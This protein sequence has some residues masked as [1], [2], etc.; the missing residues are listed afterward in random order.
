MFCNIASNYICG[1]LVMQ[2]Q[3]SYDYSLQKH[4]WAALSS[5]RL[6]YHASIV[7]MLSSNICKKGYF[8]AIMK[9]FFNHFALNHT[10]FPK[11][12]PKK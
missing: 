10:A 9:N 8:Y 4:I 6:C 3:Y 5:L 1:K 11:R 12:G 7:T 2:K